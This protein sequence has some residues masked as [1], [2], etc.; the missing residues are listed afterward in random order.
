MILSHVPAIMNEAEIE[1]GLINV[2]GH[3]HNNGPERWEPKYKER[4]TPNHYLLSLEEV[5]YVPVSLEKVRRR[6]YVKDAFN[7]LK[8]ENKSI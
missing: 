3:F 5:N 7:M 6:K 1:R 2:F 4:I 8:S